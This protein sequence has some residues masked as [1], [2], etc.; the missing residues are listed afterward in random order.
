MSEKLFEDLARKHPD[1]MQKSQIGEDLGVDEGWFDLIDTLC[2][3]ISSKVTSLRSRIQYA[4]EKDTGK[5]AE[6]EEQLAKAIAELPVIVE[7]KEKFG[8]LRFYVEGGT[9]KHHSYIDF[10]EQM[11]YKICET[12]GD[13]GQ[14]RQDRWVKVR[15]DKHQKEWEDGQGLRD[16]GLRKKRG[17][18]RLSDEDSEE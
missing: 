9:E 2:E 10:A 5:A 8:G 17:P 6:L 13:R 7:V 3:L 18:P 15:C 14:S 16:A 11:S 1:L 4:L 12:C